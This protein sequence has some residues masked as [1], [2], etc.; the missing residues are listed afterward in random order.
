MSKPKTIGDILFRQN[1]HS[2]APR[3]RLARG[4]PSWQIPLDEL[5]EAGTL[6]LAKKSWSGGRSQTSNRPIPTRLPDLL[7]PQPI[8]FTPT[9]ALAATTTGGCRRTSRTCKTFRCGT[10]ERPKNPPRLH[11]TPVHQLGS[12]DYSKSIAALAESPTSRAEAAFRDGLDIHAMTDSEMFG[13]G[14]SGHPSECAAG[15]MAINFGSI[16]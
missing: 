3:P 14:R 15:P 7:H 9:I 12:A 5:A 16:Y 8:A 4:R 10:E 2:R 1:G 6:S 13:R 11:A